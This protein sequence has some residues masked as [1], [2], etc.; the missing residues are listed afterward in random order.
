MF[1]AIPTFAVN[2]CLKKRKKRAKIAY[3][4]RNSACWR[5]WNPPLPDNE[6]RVEANFAP[7]RQADDLLPGQRSY[8]GWNS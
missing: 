1:D 8:V 7:L 6:S 3:Y 2:I 4:E 5:F